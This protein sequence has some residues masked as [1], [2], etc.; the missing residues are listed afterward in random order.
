M[1]VMTLTFDDESTP[2]TITYESETVLPERSYQISVG[3]RTN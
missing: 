2:K 1:T 3:E